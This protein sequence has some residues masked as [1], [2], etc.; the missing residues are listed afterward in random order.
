MSEYSNNSNFIYLTCY[1]GLKNNNFRIT[2][3]AIAS[4]TIS[5]I[6]SFITC[7]TSS[8]LNTLIIYVL[9]TNKELLTSTN[10][11]FGLLSLSDLCMGLIVQPIN[12]IICLYDTFEVSV[13]EL[14][15]TYSFLAY[16]FGG[17]SATTIFAISA[18]RCIGL[19]PSIITHNTDKKLSRKYIRVVACIWMLW[20]ILVILVYSKVV[21]WLALHIVLAAIIIIG[22]IVTISSYSRIN[23]LVR[24]NTVATMLHQHD[25]LAQQ[26]K[27]LERKR[28]QLRRFKTVLFIVL[29]HTTC[30][31]GRLA[32]ALTKIFIDDSSDFSGVYIC[33]RTAGIMMFLS[34]TINPLIYSLQTRSVKKRTKHL[35]CKILRNLWCARE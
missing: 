31:S 25:R 4:A 14:K 2:H 17:L 1:A 18:K 19:S 5:M 28:E 9:A 7:T 35:L 24:R 3:S 29:L 6:T 15:F 20:T 33:G 26:K 23:F 32:C 30:Y 11:L 34:N 13:C 21:P 12:A 22:L 10:I 27:T 8:I 16:V